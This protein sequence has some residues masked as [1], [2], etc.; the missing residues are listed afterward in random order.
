MNTQT[1]ANAVS[2]SLEMVIKQIIN[3]WTTQNKTITDFFNKYDDDVYLNEV[4][5][6]RNRA[7][8]LLGHLIASNDGMIPLFG[9][10]EKL[11]PELEAIFL[12]NADKSITEIPSVTLLKQYWETLNKTL[13]DHF[14]SMHSH[15][16]LERHSKVSEE[17]FALDPLRNK[18]NVL[19][20]R[21]NHESYHRGQLIFLNHKG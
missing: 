1:T 16:W 7:A 14:N 2:A 3:A 19:I 13:T 15:E 6:G 11:F 10:G 21:T 5:P 9:L 18:L 17:D 4:S 8:Y 20:G 12:T